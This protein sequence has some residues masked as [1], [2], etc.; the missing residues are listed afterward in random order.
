[1]EEIIVEPS[2]GTLASGES[3]DLT[4]TLEYG[5]MPPGDYSG[6]ITITGSDDGPIEM[7]V[8]FTILFAPVP[9]HVYGEWEVQDESVHLWWDFDWSESAREDRP[10]VGFQIFRRFDDAD[11]GNMPYFS[12]ND[13]TLT[14]WYDEDIPLAEIDSVV[15]Y[16]MKAIYTPGGPSDFGNE[17]SL[18]IAN[19]I[20]DEPYTDV[21]EAFVLSQNFPNP[22]NPET[23]ISYAIPVTEHVTLNIYNANG[24]MIRT[25]VDE[26]QVANYY[27]ATWD[28]RDD[29]GKEVPGGVYFYT[30][31]AGSFTQTN[32]MVLLK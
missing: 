14:E 7:P 8:M 21:P 6:M 20:G 28:G 10:L 31:E 5:G 2:S 9:P 32:R 13:T 17:V 24:Q 25:L 23:K 30:I 4:V 15:H 11:Y 27:T 16:S 18:E 22:F 3:V 29:T 1:M 26:K 12:T 19:I